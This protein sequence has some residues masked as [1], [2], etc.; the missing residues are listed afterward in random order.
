M[1]PNFSSQEINK[2]E[3]NYYDSLKYNYSFLNKKIKH[4][5][6][7]ILIYQPYVLQK[8]FLQEDHK[9]YIPI[10]VYKQTEKKYGR[11]KKGE[12]ILKKPNHSKYSFDNIMRKIKVYYH[13]YIINFINDYIKKIFSYQKRK[14]RRI[15]YRIKQKIFRDSFYVLFGI[16]H[17]SSLFHIFSFVIIFQFFLLLKDNLNQIHVSMEFVHLL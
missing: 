12:I 14:L 9:I 1:N 11:R 8:S 16:F 17:F 6:E 13:N 3:N 15:K 4:F 2:N 5:Q 7:N 10:P